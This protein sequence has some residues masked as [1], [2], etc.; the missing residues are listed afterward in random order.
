M[1]ATH[2]E[3]SGPRDITARIKRLGVNLKDLRRPNNEIAKRIVAR[4]RQRLARGV[5]VSGYA[6]RS[7]LAKR[8][9][10]APLGGADGLFGRSIH[11]RVGSDGAIDL[12]SDFVGAG[13]AYH[14]KT[15][16][17]KTAQFL[18]VPLE[19]ERDT[20][21]VRN[22]DTFLLRVNGKLF[23]V[24]REGPKSKKLRFLIYLT[25]RIR[26]PKNEWLGYSAAD[27]D[28]ATDDYAAHLDTFA[29]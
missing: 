9:G 14:G 19:D 5:D 29:S 23:V 21:A 15:I 2:L 18:A 26:Y 8:L 25:K 10:L 24:A 6:L 20:R 7:G 16:T 1:I 11:A 17:P 4:N 3:S 13:V 27:L 12:Y 22:K 28:S